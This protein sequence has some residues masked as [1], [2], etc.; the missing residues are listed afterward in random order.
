MKTVQQ[1]VAA[2][3][4]CTQIK[5]EIKRMYVMPDSGRNCYSNS[6]CFAMG[7][8]ASFHELHTRNRKKYPE[9]IALYQKNGF[10]EIMANTLA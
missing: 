2:P 8:R 3:L 6:S 10:T 1:L 5:F 4:K 7:K 9:A